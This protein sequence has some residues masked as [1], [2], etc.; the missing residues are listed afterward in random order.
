MRTHSLVCFLRTVFARHR[1]TLVLLG[2]L[3]IAGLIFL[4]VW[5]SAGKIA[6]F[7]GALLVI[8]RVLVFCDLRRHHLRYAPWPLTITALFMPQA[9][10]RRYLEA[11]ASGFYELRGRLRRRHMWNAIRTAPRAVL[12]LWHLWLREKWVALAVR[13]LT[14]RVH[15]IQGL[16][17][18]TPPGSRRHRAARRRL[19]RYCRLILCATGTWQYDEIARPARALL[20]CRPSE[21]EIAELTTLTADLV[22][23]LAT[24][25]P[26]QV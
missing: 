23:T 5:R 26:D 20:R 18:S 24:W 2:I 19:R 17:E 11:L 21:G 22:R 9:D 7:A 4:V 6:V 15:L 14:D 13:G 8:S 12:A 16:I 25:R 1:K 3:A 10:A